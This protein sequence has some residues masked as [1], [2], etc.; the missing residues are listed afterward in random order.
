MGVEDG[1]WCIVVCAVCLVGAGGCEGIEND[2][3][4]CQKWWTSKAKHASPFEE[5]TPAHG[6]DGKTGGTVEMVWGGT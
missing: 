4:S 3:V 1:R 5:R 2:E 6:V